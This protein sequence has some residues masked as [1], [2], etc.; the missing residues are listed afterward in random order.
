MWINK[1]D[2][3]KR[4]Y[5]EIDESFISDL[6]DLDDLNDTEEEEEENMDID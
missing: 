2:N 4:K 1:V 3:R 5:I 6:I